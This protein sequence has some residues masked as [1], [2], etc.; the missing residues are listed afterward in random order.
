[1]RFS[2]SLFLII[3]CTVA[4]GQT[5]K[6]KPTVK[7]GLK[8]YALC[9]CLAKAYKKDSIDIKDVSISVLFELSDYNF[10]MAHIK[11]IDS[12]TDTIVAGIKPLQHADYGR[13]KAVALRCL[14]YYKSKELAW[15]IR[16]FN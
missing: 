2:L 9:S 3:C 1:M 14:E 5:N 16:R 12:L 15:M 8:D 4:F 13:K 7:D 11:K 10:N 6:A